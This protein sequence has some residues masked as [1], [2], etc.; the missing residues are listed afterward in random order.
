MKKEC[1][2][3]FL[4][5]VAYFENGEEVF[6]ICCCDDCGAEI[7]LEGEKINETR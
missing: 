7:S 1:E 6:L 2:H 5:P 3:I 4:N